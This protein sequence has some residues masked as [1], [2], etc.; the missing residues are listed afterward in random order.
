MK[1][2]KSNKLKKALLRKKEEEKAKLEKKQLE[3]AKQVKVF[4]LSK[5]IRN[6][7]EEFEKNFDEGKV[8]AHQPYANHQLN[9]P[10][11]KKW[12]KSTCLHLIDQGV[13]LTSKNII[14]KKALCIICHIASFEH[15]IIRDVE[16]WVS[17]SY[18][19]ERQMSSFLRHLFAKY[20]VPLFMDHVWHDNNQTRQDWF[21]HV[22]KG[23]N[24]RKAYGL[25]VELTKREAHFMM[26]SP[27][28]FTVT[29][30]IRYG[31]LLNI[32]ANIHFVKQIFRTRAGIDFTNN[33]FWMSVYR[34]FLDNPML[35]NEHYAPIV[36][37]IY[38]Q[39][40]VNSMRIGD[41]WVPP[42]PNLSMKGRDANST[43]KAVET[44]HKAL[45]KQKG[46]ASSWNHSNISEFNYESGK[47]ED[48]KIYRI[49]ELTTKKELISEGHTMKHCVASYAST[50]AAGLNSIWSLEEY[51][52]A[53]KSKLLTLQV[54]KNR[55]IVQ[56]RGKWNAKPSA[57]ERNLINMW[58]NQAGLT[59]SKWLI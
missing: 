44:W 50:C 56:A 47:G 27:R 54:D 39:K 42:Q 38:N 37:W 18:N 26:Q 13:D 55:Q 21:I 15:E 41:N 52:L 20:D 48:K 4:V 33:D 12:I 7:K 49:Y 36:D 29:Q 8:F 5:K 10:S 40:F 30:A 58:C 16:S 34:W 2:V 46:D 28:D 51:Y 23:L 11:N 24:I 25:P 45:G 53:N 6:V 59:I 1:P 22:G 14:S 3:T 19:I 35:D 32:G 43:L 31:Q 57:S 9:I 17:K